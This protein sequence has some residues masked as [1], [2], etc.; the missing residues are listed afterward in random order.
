MGVAVVEVRDVVV[1]VLDRIMVVTVAVSAD[2][3][4]GMFVVVVSIVV[5]VLVL[6]IERRMTVGML[7]AGP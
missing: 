5:C 3:V 2:G 4:T 6:M 1:H 7:M